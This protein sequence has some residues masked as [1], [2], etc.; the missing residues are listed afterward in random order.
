MG[1]NF[2]SPLKNTGTVPWDYEIGDENYQI[3]LGTKE[4]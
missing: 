1:Q 4:R 3:D 2:N